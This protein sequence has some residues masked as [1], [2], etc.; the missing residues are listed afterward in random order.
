MENKI[1]DIVIIG[2]GPAGLT[3]AIYNAR[4]GLEPVVLA[5]YEPGG[6]LIKTTIVENFPGFPDGIDGPELMSRFRVQA[7]KFGAQVINTDVKQVALAGEVK[8]IITLEG[9]E[10]LAKSVI[11]ATG[12]TPRKLTIPGEDEYYG[13]GVSTCATCD[14]ALFKNKVIAVIGGGD[15]AMQE[16]GFL[17]RFASKV[18]LIHRR[19]LFKASKIMIDRV[20]NNPKIEVIY[21]TEVKEVVGQ[22]GR[23][24]HLNLLNTKTN[25]ESRLEIAGMFLAIGHVPVTGF[26]NGVALTP[27]GYVESMDGVNTNVEGVFVA[28]DVQDSVFRQAVTAAGMGAMA[29][30]TAQKWLE[31]KGV[32]IIPGY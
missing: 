25:Q 31:G 15:S 21:N 16:A 30:I 11:L 14:G 23:V 10:Y 4:A 32:T 17:T 20:L 2:S 29:A 19:D 27:A 18:Y 7:E 13:R 26:L 28:G 12:A 22:D 5:G 9:Q 6:Q 1:H 24:H 8:K 3:A